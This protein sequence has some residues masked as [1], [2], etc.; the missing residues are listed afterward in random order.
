MIDKMDDAAAAAIRL[1]AV[2][3]IFYIFI[4]NR[5]HVSVATVKRVET[6]GFIDW[7]VY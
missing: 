6:N 1:H 5:L 2:L 7:S 3:G 4:F